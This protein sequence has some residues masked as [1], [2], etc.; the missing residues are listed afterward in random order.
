MKGYLQKLVDRKFGK[1]RW[2]LAA[3]QMVVLFCE[4]YHI[5]GSAHGYDLYTHIQKAWE[6]ILK[7]ENENNDK[8]KF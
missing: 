4:K 6:K 3:N 8:W 5:A 7:E 2:D 1:D